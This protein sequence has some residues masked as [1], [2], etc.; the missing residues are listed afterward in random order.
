M[1]HLSISIKLLLLLLI[2]AGLAIIIGLYGIT[3][4]KTT[5]QSLETVYKD[6]VVPLNQLK[7]VSDMYA[8]NIVDA[9]HKVSNANNNWLEGQ[10]MIEKAEKTIEENWSAY[11]STY[12]V[13]E[14]Q[15]KVDEAQRLMEKANMSIKVL[16][17][18]VQRR[19]TAELRHYIKYDL[20]QKIDPITESISGLMELQ[21]KIAEHEYLKGQTLYANTRRNS[22]L[23]MGGGILLAIAISLLIIRNINVSLRNANRLVLRLAEG[24]LSADMAISGNDEI[25]KLLRNLKAMVE[26]LK[27][28][29]SH[30]LTAANNIAAA[31][32]QMSATSQ[33]MSQGASEQAASTEEVSTSMEQMTANIQQNTDNAQQTETIASK[34]AQ[35]ILKGSESVS[36]TVKAMILIAEKI[37]IIQ[38][39]ANK[40]DLLAVNA[41]I[42]S[43][44]AGEH[45]D[46]FAVVASE[47]RKL[48]E[49]SQKAANEIS[50]I[51]HKSVEVAELSG[52][53]L[54]EIVPDI[55][56]TSRLVQ[57]ISASS[58]EQ[59]GG[60]AQINTAIQQLNQVTQQNA[61]AAE[62]MATS[63]EELASQ[64]DQLKET[65]SFFKIDA[66]ALMASKVQRPSRKKANNK[67]P[68]PAVMAEGYHFN[69][70][71]EEKDENYENY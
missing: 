4:L 42:E 33:N 53:L 52:S 49:H 19:D 15:S 29:I 27:G 16:G 26:R 54:S 57:E 63:S 22:F 10:H 1:K 61:A 41:A 58:T 6:R 14:E 38:E 20:Y 35:D 60:A 5:N 50:D 65:I 67:S 7:K 51:S 44:R 56:N 62:E 70:E 21:L 9:A 64:A 45:G 47:V 23:L 8:V 24:D 2:T 40:T 48:A 34:A 32:G 68:Q 18:I 46:G 28:V 71:E 37:K 36:E 13:G 55:Q 43:A 11:L 39:I 12:I 69:M 30:V 25:A 59:N 3:N 31:S 17:D 66:S